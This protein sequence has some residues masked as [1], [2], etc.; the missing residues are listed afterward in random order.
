MKK[1]LSI[2]LALI[3]LL[4]V[5]SMASAQGTR[6][7]AIQLVNLGTSPADIVINYYNAMDASSQPGELKCSDNVDDLA[8]LA[9]VEYNHS[10][11][12]S[13]IASETSWK[14]SI[15]IESTE[16]IAVITNINELGQ[17]QGGPN[18]YYAGGSYDGIAD[19]KTA[20][21]VVLPIIMYD[22]YTYNTDFAVQNAGADDAQVTLKYIK[23][24][25]V[26]TGPGTVDTKTEGPFTVKPGASLYRDQKADDSDLGST[27]QGVVIVESTQPVAAVVNQY[28]NT[29]GTLLNYEGFAAGDDTIYMPFMARE[30]F[31]FSTF[32]SVVAMEDGTAGTVE[33]FELG[34]ATPDA[35]LNVSLDEYEVLG[36]NQKT[37]TAYDTGSI[38]VG[39]GGAAVVKLTSGSAVAVVNERGE[40]KQGHKLGLT[41]SGMNGN[42]IKSKMVFPYIIRKYAKF[43]WNTSFQIM[44]TGAK[45][46]VT[47]KYNPLAGTS[48]SAYTWTSGDLD[49][50]QA[51]ECN[52][53][54]DPNSCVDTDPGTAGNQPLPDGWVG[55]VVVEGEA[56]VVLAG[57][58]N[59]RN[60]TVAQDNGLSYN[61]F[62][63]E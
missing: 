34:K 54:L 51:L 46:K 24:T 59:V 52:Q 27:W 25:T 45:G 43:K 56:G 28:P 41:Y 31:G 40:S 63:Y 26:P 15:V 47:V 49:P 10:G 62:P 8:P 16:P 4:G 2:T 21:E 30:Y 58:C 48:F 60:P 55:S 32:L 5:V 20:G 61:G 1:L 22:Y 9:G 44:N 18:V 35:T 7:T 53:L 57:I 13:C 11:T 29:Q 14:G 38:P 33:F 3:M 6:S 23:S 12:T 39:W 19:T 37:D 36:W 42:A 17:S 50:N